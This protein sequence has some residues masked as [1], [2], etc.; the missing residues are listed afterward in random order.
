MLV[1][2]GLVVGIVD[3]GLFVVDR[4]EGQHHG[5]H[6]GH[7]VAVF[8]HLGDKGL[9][10]VE[11]G[12]D[13][14]VVLLLLTVGLHIFLQFD[15]LHAAGGVKLVEVLDE[16]VDVA[17]VELAR[18]R[19]GEALAH[20]G[21]DERAGEHV[22][23]LGG[24]HAKAQ[25]GGLL[26][27]EGLV[28]KL[29][30]H[31]LAD[32]LL[33]LR[34]HLGGLLLHLVVVFHLGNLLVETLRGHSLAV[35]LANVGDAAVVF[36]QVAQNER[37]NGNTDYGNGPAGMLPNSSNNSHFVSYLLFIIIIYYFDV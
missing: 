35:H 8:G 21:V 23:D 20:I 24:A 34:R 32:L 17:H 12:A 1:V 30:P 16:L 31:L 26:L 18:L 36:R 15:P 33:H 6:V 22:V 10:H 37:Q 2:V 9:G 27:H 28:H 4:R 29:L 19:V 5:T 13:Q 11:T 25:L 14:R 7:S 3:G